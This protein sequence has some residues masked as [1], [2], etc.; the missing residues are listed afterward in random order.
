MAFAQKVPL[1]EL[2]QL[3][4]SCH[5]EDGNSRSEKVPSLAGQPEFRVLFQLVLMREGVRRVETM[6][7]LVK[8]LKDSEM[9]FLAKHF[10]KLVPKP[11]GEPIDAALVRRG[12]EIAAQKQCVSCHLPT[13]AGQQQVP[14]LAKQRVDYLIQAL[15]EFRD[16]TRS[17]SD[18]L[19]NG[20]VTGLSDADLTAL[21][22]Y[23]AS[24]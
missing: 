17:G 21:A 20:A 23:A 5:G 7:E 6:V 16:S 4:A 3:C 15:K 14:R 24:R 18:T 19:M 22:H 8:D 1:A 11:S 12:S 10:A 9:D 2:V 13:L